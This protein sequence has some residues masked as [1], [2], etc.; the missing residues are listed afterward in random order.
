MNM[1]EKSVLVNGTHIPSSFKLGSHEISVILD[2]SLAHTDG[3]IGRTDYMENQIRL[4]PP[5]KHFPVAAS[6]QEQVFWH[7]TV[8]WIFHHL[9]EEKL[10][11]NEK[12]VDQIASCIQQILN[13]MEFG[14][15]ASDSEEHS[16]AKLRIAA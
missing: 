10:R 5:V 13:T 8:H 14:C 4:M 12:L 1:Q 7:E 11:G 9:G 2:D 6:R 15:A 3:C 16:P